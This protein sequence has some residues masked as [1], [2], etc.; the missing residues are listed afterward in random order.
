[1]T[2]YHGTL[3]AAVAGRGATG[4]ALLRTSAAAP[5]R[6]PLTL[7][8]G[9]AERARSRPS[10]RVQRGATVDTEKDRQKRK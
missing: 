9:G 10:R 8:V 3:L 4:D 2:L 7:A 6:E 5:L 1:M